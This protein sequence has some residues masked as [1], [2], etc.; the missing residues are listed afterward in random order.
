M[1]E[2]EIGTLIFYKLE[3]KMSLSVEAKAKI[4]SEFGRGENDSGSTE[5][6]V[7]C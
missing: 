4:V 3:L 2:L 1:A 6:Q 7:A 5:V